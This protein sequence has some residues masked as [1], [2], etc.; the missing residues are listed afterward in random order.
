MG[1]LTWLIPAEAGI[2]IILWI[3]TII[4]AQAF[5]V[6]D[7]KYYPAVIIGLFPALAAWTMLVV[8]TALGA[9]G[10]PLNAS[11]VS[12]AHAAGA[13]L[14]GGFALEQGFLYSAM[15]WSAVVVCIVDRAWSKAATWCGV[16]ALLALS[17]LMH[18]YALTGRDTVIDLPLLAMLSGEWREGRS[19]FPAGGAALG[20][21]L[22]GV[23]FLGAKFIT[24]PRAEDEV[25]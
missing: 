17:G 11:V 9:G 22:A 6:T 20:Y 8:K 1:A 19:I 5:E 23:A 18:S 24:V 15:I 3:G 12:A 25:A 7:K 14:G 13:Y 2:A 4:A 10:A 21:A 16:G